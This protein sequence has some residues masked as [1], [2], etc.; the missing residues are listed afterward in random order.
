MVQI[1]IDAN[2]IP[3]LPEVVNSRPKVRQI[4]KPEKYAIPK[5]NTFIR[6]FRTNRVII[7]VFMEN[8]ASP[9]N[10][11]NQRKKLKVKGSVSGKVNLVT[12]KPTPPN[13]DAK[14]ANKSPKNICF[15]EKIMQNY[16]LFNDKINF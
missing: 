7:N 11:K 13:P 15:L 5:M 3:A 12:E 16:R 6:S 4:G 14:L 8:S 9:S 2:K 10:I 1:G